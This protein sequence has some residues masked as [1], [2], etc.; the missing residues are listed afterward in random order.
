MKKKQNY[1]PLQLSFF[2]EFLTHKNYG[3]DNLLDKNWKS[4]IDH[5][6]TERSIGE[7][8]KQSINQLETENN[9]R[10]LSESNSGK[11]PGL[12]D[13]D[14]R[15]NGTDFGT[16]MER[17]G[18]L[19]NVEGTTAK[20]IFTDETI[21]RTDSI[22]AEDLNELLRPDEPSHNRQ[23]DEGDGSRRTRMAGIDE[24]GWSELAS[25]ESFMD[26]K[27]LEIALPNDKD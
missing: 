9:E 23:W 27:L 19:R 6:A 21:G 18:T 12:S 5:F 14:Q 15:R 24:S 11:R 7:K 25:L 13:A 8:E 16:P 20:S 4:V 10:D 26:F 1:N 2:D 3:N 17:E 22:S